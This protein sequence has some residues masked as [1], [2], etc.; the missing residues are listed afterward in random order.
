MAALA[1]TDSEQVT[2]YVQGLFPGLGAV[3]RSDNASMIGGMASLGAVADS[4]SATHYATALAPGLDTVARSD[5]VIAIG[6]M[7]QLGA[8][9]GAGVAVVQEY[10]RRLQVALPVIAS[11]GSSEAIAAMWALGRLSFDAAVQQAYN[12]AFL[13]PQC[14]L[15]SNKAKRPRES[16]SGPAGSAARTRINGAPSERRNPSAGRGAR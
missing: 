4:W 1:H 8:R 7:A 16:S 6:S 5:N 10:A 15:W 12:A 3:V 9:V 13:S 11:S 14:S 2:A